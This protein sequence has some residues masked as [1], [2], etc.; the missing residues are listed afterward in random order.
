E[1]LLVVLE[2]DRRHRRGERVRVE[3]VFLLPVE[4]VRGH[5]LVDHA[6]G[7]RHVR[8]GLE[9]EC[10]APARAIAAVD[11]LAAAR[12]EGIGPAGETG[13]VGDRQYGRGIDQ[14]GVQRRLQAATGAAVGDLVRV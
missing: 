13:A 8:V 5:L 12:T 14:G 4:A 10:K 9:G 3:V 6:R 2:G 11:V 7:D 1:V